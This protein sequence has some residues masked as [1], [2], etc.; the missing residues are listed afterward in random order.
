MNYYPF[1]IG[2]Y[3]AHTA[4]LTPIEDIAYR[5]CLDAYY[6]REGALPHEPFE[7][8]RLIRMRDEIDAVKQILTE[9]FTHGEFGWIHARCDEEIERMQDK[10]AK[11]RASAEA[12][13]NARRAK[14]EQKPSERLTDVQRTLNERSTDVEL[15]TPTPTPTPIDLNTGASAK[16]GKPAIVSKPESVPDSVW[17]D[18]TAIRKTKRAPLTQTALDGI[19]REANKAGIDLAT[20]LQECCARGWQGFKA[21]WY[22]RAS[23]NGSRATGEPAWRTEQRERIQ[24]AVPSIA[25]RPARTDYI[26]AEVS[27]AAPRLLG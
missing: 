27:H 24:Q 16:R 6:L 20:A 4:H 26:D 18:F 25:A 3:A 8:A 11:A 19:E 17:H 22:Q 21:D 5:R 23:L 2:D 1:H 14:A 15:P 10:Q 9:F 7:I 13:V 12:S